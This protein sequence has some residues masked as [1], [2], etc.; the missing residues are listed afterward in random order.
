MPS[1]L[2]VCLS[3]LVIVAQRFSTSCAPGVPLVCP[4]AVRAKEA[5]R[6]RW[7]PECGQVDQHSNTVLSVEW[8]VAHK[9]QSPAIRTY[10]LSGAV[11]RGPTIGED[12]CLR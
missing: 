6:L 11:H 12:Q 8:V 7:H 2:Q 9:E 5:V 3:T 1:D 4:R 10:W